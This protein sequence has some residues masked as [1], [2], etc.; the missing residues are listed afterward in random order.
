MP[1]YIDT[2]P[3]ADL[4][5]GDKRCLDAA[6]TAIVLCRAD[7]KLHAFVNNCPHAGL[8]LGDGELRRH[9]ITC[10][11]HG[12]TF[13]I[14]TGRNIDFPEQEQPLTTLPVRVEDDMIQVDVETT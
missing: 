3:D 11:F 6:G 9:V 2:L 13:D 4:P 7:G 8:P 5:E 14:R 1:R 10:P 12:Y